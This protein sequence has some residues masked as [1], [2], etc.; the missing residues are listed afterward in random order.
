MFCQKFQ[1]WIKISF[2]RLNIV[3][4]F[5]RQNYLEFYKEFN[6]CF[7]TIVGLKLGLQIQKYQKELDLKKDSKICSA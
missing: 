7:G 5:E 3:V 6:E 1:I 4:W 2:Y